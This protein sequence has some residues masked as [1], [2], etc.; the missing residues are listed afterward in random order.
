MAFRSTYA[1]RK[2]ENTF[3]VAWNYKKL[4]QAIIHD[5]FQRAAGYS[6]AGFSGE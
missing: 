6:E 1:S 5:K 4:A 2:R 3:H